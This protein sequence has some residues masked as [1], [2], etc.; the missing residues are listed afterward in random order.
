[1]LTTP[2]E[3]H[4]VVLGYGEFGQNIS[5][6]L[7]N[8]GE[9]YIIVE[10]NIDKY[11]IAK[12]NH[13]SVIFGNA[14]NKTILQKT[15]IRKANKVIVAIDNPK[16]LYHLCEEVQKVVQVNKII[17]KVHAIRERKALLELGIT[18]I[19]VENEESSQAI[20]RYI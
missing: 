14:E 6:K 15:F 8:D 7:K 5:A 10:N 3:G 2:V 16:K 1:L 4:V 18:N 17:V 9:F 19:I 12:Q 13:E 11:H 20:L